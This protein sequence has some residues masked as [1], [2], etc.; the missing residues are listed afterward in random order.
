MCV[1]INFVAYVHMIVCLCLFK[2]MFM[3]IFIFMFTLMLGDPELQ[4]A[5]YN[6][7]V[8]CMLVD[9]QGM[10]FT[11]LCSCHVGTHIHISYSYSCSYSDSYYC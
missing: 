11:A 9:M 3:I 2:I 8:M 10:T 7:C 6:G 4:N 5:Y 1:Y